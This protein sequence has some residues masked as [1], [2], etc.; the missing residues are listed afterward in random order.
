MPRSD[1]LLAALRLVIA[2]TDQDQ[3]KLR[4]ILNLGPE[5]IESGQYMHAAPALLRPTVEEM[6]RRLVTRLAGEWSMP[7]RDVSEV[8]NC[9]AAAT[10]ATPQRNAALET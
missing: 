8:I 9:F 6:R 3:L 5:L 7:E 4:Q 2:L 1:Q 10:P